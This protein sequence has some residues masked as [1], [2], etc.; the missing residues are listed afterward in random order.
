MTIGGD[1]GNTWQFNND[2]QKTGELIRQQHLKERYIPLT[3]ESLLQ[4]KV[5]PLDAFISLQ[6]VNKIYPNR[7]QAVFD[8]NL[9][10]KE[11]EFI[12]GPLLSF[13]WIET[14]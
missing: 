8:F 3:K 5:A 14:L 10:I 4:D 9:D 1:G 12:V 7:V 6:N 2:K 11:K 13:N